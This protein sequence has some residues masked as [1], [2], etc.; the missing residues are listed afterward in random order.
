MA[1]GEVVAPEAWDGAFEDF[2]TRPVI[3][4]STFSAV[5]NIKTGWALHVETDHMI[6]GMAPHGAGKF[7]AR[8]DASIV[9]ATDLIER[10]DLGHDVDTARWMGDFEQSETVMAAVTVHEPESLYRFLRVRRKTQLHQV[11]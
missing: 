4:G 8:S 3:N 2:I 9:T 5:L 10:I 1:Y 7:Y 6:V 11:G